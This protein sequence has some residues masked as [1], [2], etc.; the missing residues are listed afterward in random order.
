[1]T[2]QKGNIES[3]WSRKERKITINND[4]SKKGIGIPTV[5]LVVFVVLKL[6]GVIKW[7]WLW[8]LSPLWICVGIYI[9]LFAIVGITNC[10]IMK[11][12]EKAIKE[13]DKIMNDKE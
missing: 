7:S 9:I 8:V 10:I 2:R 6:I 4:N 12:V 11:K 1:M 3:I 5:L 13:I